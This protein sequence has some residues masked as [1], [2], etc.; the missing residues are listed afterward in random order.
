MSKS[1][2]LVASTLCVLIA[3]AA[4]LAAHAESV[5]RPVPTP[6]TSKL[7]PDAAARIANERAKIEKQMPNLIGPPLAQSYVELGGL[8]ARNGFNEAAAVAFYDASQISPEDARW[9]YLRGVVALALKQDSEAKSEFQSALDR[10]KVYVPISVRLAG[11][12]VDLNDYAGARKVL[13]EARGNHPKDAILYSMLGDLAM[14][15]KR[16]A[17]AIASYNQALQ[18]EPKADGLYA[19]LADANAAKGNKKAADEARAKAGK[20][21]PELADPL[22]VNMYRQT[23]EPLDQVRMLANTGNLAGARAKLAELLKA[24]PND[25]PTLT[26]AAGLEAQTSNAAAAR[27]YADRALKAK[28]DSAATH[29]MSGMVAEYAG[30]DNKAY[31]EYRRAQKLDPK[32]ADAWLMRGDAEM[33]RKRYGDAV[34]SYRGYVA[35]QPDNGVAYAPLVAALVAQGKCG[36]AQNE[37]AGALGKYKNNGDLMQLYARVASTCPDAN[38]R[39]RDTALQYAKALY[40]QRPN[41]EDS[42]AYALA[43]AAHGK[44]K[45]AQ[46]YQAEAIFESLRSGDNAAAALYKSTMQLFNKNQLPDRPWPADHPYFTAPMMM[47]LRVTAVPAPASTPTGKH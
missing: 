41:A 7:P 46:E 1:F 9:Y 4:L 23:L 47:P 14:K 6:D 36:D 24:N 15:E 27:D 8:Y 13:E 12:L 45:E 2:R 37:L 42:S 30:D 21:M 33:R 17:D 43:M 20:A 16:Y 38:V 11:T 5:L 25:V 35:L 32:S 28:P 39:D 18:R 34:D 19:K 3:F 40:Q 29:L 10:D 22:V 44:F 26:L 31:D